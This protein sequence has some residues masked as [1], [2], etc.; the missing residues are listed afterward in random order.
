MVAITAQA[1]RT[2]TGFGFVASQHCAL[3][4]AALAAV[5]DSSTADLAV[6]GMHIPAPCGT[7]TDRL[8]EDQWS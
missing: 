4:G 6:T 1:P 5:Q 8:G 2:R 7:A 3:L